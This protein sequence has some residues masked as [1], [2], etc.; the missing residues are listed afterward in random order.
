[1]KRAVPGLVVLVLLA[2]AQL[3][4]QSMSHEEEVVRN[5]YAKLSFMCETSTITEAAIYSRLALP[6]C[7]SSL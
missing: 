1:M 4:A 6:C 3:P 5:A 2:V 7:L